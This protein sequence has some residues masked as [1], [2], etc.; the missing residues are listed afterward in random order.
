MAFYQKMGAQVFISTK[1][2]VIAALFLVVRCGVY[3]IRN[4][5]LIALHVPTAQEKRR[6]NPIILELG[7]G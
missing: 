4:K 1:I 2:L 7:R 6:K 5:D 3:E